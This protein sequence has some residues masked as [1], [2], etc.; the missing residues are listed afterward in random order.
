MNKIAI[1]I[2]AGLLILVIGFLFGLNPSREG[3]GSVAIGGESQGTTTGSTWNTPALIT[4]GFKL[5][6]CS[7]GSLNNVVIDTATA[8]SFTLYDATTTVNGAIYGTTTIARVSASVAAGSHAYDRA[9][10]YGIIAEFQSPNVASSTITF[11]G[12]PVCQ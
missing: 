10:K 5:L 3:Y 6:S 2:G 8:G 4:G 7:A 9:V 1:G 12:N 11:R